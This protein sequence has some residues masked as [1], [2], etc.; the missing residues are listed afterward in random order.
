MSAGVGG[1]TIDVQ[2]LRRPPQWPKMKPE[3]RGFSTT[4]A[5]SLF[6]RLTNSLRTTLSAG[7]CRQMVIS[8]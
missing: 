5:R 6:H 3:F 4:A 1:V 2:R 8:Q 7:A